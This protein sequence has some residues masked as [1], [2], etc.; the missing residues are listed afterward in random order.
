MIGTNTSPRVARWLG[1]IRRFFPSSVVQVMQKDALDR[2]NLHSMLLQPEMLE[3]VQ[4][5]VN[6]VSTLMSLRTLITWAENLQ[7]LDDVAAA[8]RLAFANRCD[9]AERPLVAELFQRCFN[10]ELSIGDDRDALY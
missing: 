8:F 6:L 1:D 3:S 10:A 5:D 2:L 4:P 7:L 9:A